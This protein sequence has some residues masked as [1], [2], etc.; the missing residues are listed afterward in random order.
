[1]QWKIIPTGRVWQDAGGPFGLVPRQMWQKHQP[2]NENNQVAMDLNSLLIQSAGQNI[3]VDTGVGDKL[4]EKGIR[5]WHLTWPEGTLIENLALTGLKPEDID[6]VIDTHLHAD[7]CGGNTTI[8]NGEV[9]PTFPN[10]EYLVQYTEF[11]DA[12][13]PNE[14]TRATYLK[15]N[16]EPVWKNRQFK[17][18]FGDTQITPEVR[19]VVTRGHTRG[20][21]AILIEGEGEKALFVSDLTSFA[22]HMVRTAW[23]TAYD[24]EPLENIETKKIWQAWA[25]ENKATLIFQHDTQIRTG[26]LL[27]NDAG[28]WEMETLEKGSLG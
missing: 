24:V 27:K 19:C 9:R 14:R 15:D 12:Q 11:A 26:R 18:L 4:S 17:F 16:F 2:V 1:M 6:I 13:H 8:V 20:H 28:R 10:A 3:L 22:V 21:Q 23:V 25:L 7:H 5:N